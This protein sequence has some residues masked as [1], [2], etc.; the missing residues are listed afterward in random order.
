MTRSGY[1]GERC[2]DH[3]VL[4]VVVHVVDRRLQRN[5]GP[6]RA[7]AIRHAGIAVGCAGP[8]FAQYIRGRDCCRRNLWQTPACEQA[9]RMAGPAIND[10]QQL[11]GKSLRVRVIAQN[12]QR[13]RRGPSWDERV[14]GMTGG[15]LIR[16]PHRAAV[17]HNPPPAGRQ[18][19]GRTR[20]PA[21]S[22]VSR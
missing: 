6:S 2:E 8:A 10:R 13:E 14:P 5:V 18:A 17:A 15:F 22:I 11:G 21:M 19:A 20:A 12:T 9:S 3:R 4:C 16:L 1:E 7:A